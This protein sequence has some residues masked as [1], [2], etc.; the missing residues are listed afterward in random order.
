MLYSVEL[1]NLRSFFAVAKVRTFSELA[2]FLDNFFPKNS[3]FTAFLCNFVPEMKQTAVFLLAIMALVVV[4]STSL[5]DELKYYLD[6]HNVQ[7]E[8]YEMVVNY[9]TY[10]DTMLT[11]LPS[12]P[13]QLLNVGKWRGIVRE[14]TGMEYDSL[15]RIIIANY[16]ADTLT[17]GI[18]LDTTTVYSGDFSA[19]IANGHGCALT[20]D[21]LYYEG[22]WTDDRRNGFGFALDSTGH[23][24]VGQWQ[25]DKYM[26][27]RISYTS[28]R[29]Y[30]I[31]I[32]RYQH[33]KGNK[34]YPILWNSLRIVNLGKNQKNATGTVDY[35][36]S[37]I[38]IKS[39][40]S[41]SIRNPYYAQDY[42]R[43]RQWGIPIGAY[44]FFSCKMSGS[45]QAQYFI[46]NT[47]FRKGD[48]PPVLDLEPSPSQ[49]T[50][51]G[52]PQVMFQH[53]RAWLQAVERRAGVKPILYVSQTFVNRYLPEAPDLKR[54]YQVWIARYSEYKPDVR[55]AVWQLSPNGYVKGIHGEVDINVFNGF[56][57]QWDESLEEQTIK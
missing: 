54:D 5:H 21:G 41:T 19:G 30:G 6:R 8:G 27:E 51:M 16:E 57:T 24:R 49:I 26:G 28:E 15:G 23:L 10:G 43:A 48:L 9:A 50:A 52:G 38:F 11:H 7:D 40:E 39:T 56:K 34:K 20:T 14:G 13:L 17:N 53:V 44:H 2:K 12:E 31:D 37:F 29:I 36:V 32:S 4:A 45:A 35:P 18:R 25:L 47:L 46:M 55:L 42:M 33:G 1:R 3:V 22:Q